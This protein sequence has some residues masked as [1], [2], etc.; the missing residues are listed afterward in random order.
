M[1]IYEF[2]GNISWGYNPSFQL[3]VDKYY[4]TRDELKAFIDAAHARGMGVILDVVFNHVF[5][6]SP[7]AQLYWDNA[8]F[9]PAESNPWLNVTPKHPFNVG[10]DVIHEY[11]GTKQWVK[12]NLE[13][14]IEEYRFDG[15]RFDLSKGLTQT[16]SGNDAGLMS[17]RDPSRIAI[18]K[19]YADYI[20]SLDPDSYVI[21]E[22]FADNNEETE[23]ANYGMMLWGNMNH[24]FTEAAM[25]YSSDLE[26]ADYKVRGWNDPHL[27]AY[28][29]SHDEERMVNRILQFGDAADGYNTREFETALRRVEA[30]SSIFYSIPGPKMLW[31]FGE[32]GYEFSINYCPNGSI[33]NSCRVDPKPIRWDYLENESR[34]RLRNIMASMIYL[35]TNF[36]TFSTTDYTFSD[37]NFFIKAVYLNH[38]DMDAVT[39]ANF[40]VIE[41]NFNPKFPYT[42]TWYEFFS[43]DSIVVTDVNERVTFAPGEYRVYTSKPI[44]KPSNLTVGI[45]EQLALEAIS[46][47]PN[48]VSAGGTISV[49]YAE[50]IAPSAISLYAID[51]RQ[52]SLKGERKGN[53]LQISIP[54]EVASGIYGL[55]VEAGDKG[56]VSKIQVE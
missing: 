20:W 44:E 56:F 41:S 33:D 55:R 27:I 52:I 46:A 40:R 32:L 12:R 54:K 16:N 21:M 11:A 14:W 25:G 43:G 28:M 24:E 31:Q 4:G 2:E 23:L 47:Y 22:H 26:W 7:L 19:D 6:Q 53:L 38:P 8:N 3:A 9:R 39:L 13:Q 42:G 35:K 1:P 36:P 37:A 48:P 29:E 50:I 30:A 18:L 51:G 15:F 5:S 45:E 17:R 34:M 10:Y 49:E